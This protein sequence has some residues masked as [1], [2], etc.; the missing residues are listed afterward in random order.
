MRDLITLPLRWLIV[1]YR[2]TLSPFFGPCCR[3]HPTCSHYALAA[4]REHGLWRGGWLTLQR[5]GKCHPWHP[6]GVDEVPLAL[7]RL[8]VHRH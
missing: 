1:G 4:L 5:L 8:H 6:G 2:Y 3:F 7:R